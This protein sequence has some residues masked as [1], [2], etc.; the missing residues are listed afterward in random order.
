VARAHG[1][2]TPVQLAGALR[3]SPVH[4]LSAGMAIELEFAIQFQR[5]S[6]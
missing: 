1:R 3:F 2:L 4:P 6:P 5:H